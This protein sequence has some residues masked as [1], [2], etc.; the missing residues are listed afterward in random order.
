M[1]SGEVEKQLEGGILL[2]VGL[3]L[4]R[5]VT[6][7][8]VGVPLD[9]TMLVVYSCFWSSKL[10]TQL[11]CHSSSPRNEGRDSEAISHVE[12]SCLSQV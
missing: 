6:V 9:K 2:A 1:F 4:F 8:S 10:K 5:H 3:G 12:L 11:C 7:D